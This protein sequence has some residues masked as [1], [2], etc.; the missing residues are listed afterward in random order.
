MNI[1]HF[2]VSDYKIYNPITKEVIVEEEANEDSESIIALW[3]D[4]AIDEPL[5]KDESFKEA[6]E[7]YSNRYKDKDEDYAPDFDDILKFLKKYKNPLWKVFVVTTSGFACGPVSNTV[8][9]VV[10][11]DVIFEDKTEW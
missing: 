3:F 9:L 1:E 4:E 8:I 6:W 10:D 7:T 2:V 5:I 11:K